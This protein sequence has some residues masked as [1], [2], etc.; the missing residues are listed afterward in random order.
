M[1]E[2][3]IVIN[4][5]ESLNLCQAFRDVPNDTDT[6]Y[7]VVTS[8]STPYR[9]PT[10]CDPSVEVM[11]YGSSWKQARTLGIDFSKRIRDELLSNPNTF[12]VTVDS[13]YRDDDPDTKQPRCVVDISFTQ[14]EGNK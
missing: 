11:F 10:V 9:I 1:D 3:L 14:I 13:R 7:A 5:I 2:E 8:V 6:P 4:A 12:N